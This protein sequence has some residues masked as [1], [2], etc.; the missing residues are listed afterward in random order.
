MTKHQLKHERTHT[1]LGKLKSTNKTEV[2]E[3]RALP[4]EEPRLR[5][6]ETDSPLL[7]RRESLSR[8]IKYHRE[9]QNQAEIWCTRSACFTGKPKSEA[10]TDNRNR[11]RGKGFAAKSSTLQGQAERQHVAP[12]RRKKIWRENQAAGAARS[13]D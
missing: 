4:R 9:N 2:I 1:Q 12:K 3:T 5:R 10:A 6:T 11:A 8:R 13:H 7:C